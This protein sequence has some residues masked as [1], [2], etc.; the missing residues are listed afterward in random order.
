MRLAS[1]PIH[2]RIPTRPVDWIESIYSAEDLVHAI[3]DSLTPAVRS[4]LLVASRDLHQA[5][6]DLDE[7]GPDPG[8]RL[9]IATRVLAYLVR[10]GWRTTPFGLF[11]GI[12]L[13]TV[14]D[15]PTRLELAPR[16]EYVHGT[17]RGLPC[18]R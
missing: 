17:N 16:A 3:R 14:A 10:M 13:G 8:R 15:A 7:D 12:S 6:A 4:A 11:A 1:G 5:L 9:R 2:V 18:A